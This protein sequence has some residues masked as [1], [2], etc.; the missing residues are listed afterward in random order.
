MG[1]IAAILFMAI[2]V[3]LILVALRQYHRARTPWLR[4]LSLGIAGGT[5]GYAIVSVTLHAW[6]SLATSIVFWL[7]AGQVVRAPEIE[8]ASTEGADAHRGLA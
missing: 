4:A 1:A 2:T 3:C 8:A 6:E 7:L 5:V